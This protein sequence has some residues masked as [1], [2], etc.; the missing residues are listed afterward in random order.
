MNRYVEFDILTVG[1]TGNVQEGYES[2]LTFDAWKAQDHISTTVNRD[3]RRCELRIE[4][5]SGNAT[6]GISSLR[7][8]LA[9]MESH[10]IDTLDVMALVDR[11]EQ[12]ETVVL[13][14]DTCERVPKTDSDYL[15][16]YRM[17]VF[18]VQQRNR[19]CW[20]AYVKGCRVRDEELAKL[21]ELMVKYPEQAKSN[22]EI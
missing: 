6:V 11:D 16:E 3:V 12:V 2:V 13:Y 18:G 10:G 22:M 20:N 17:Y 14:S 1:S 19:D 9:E 21:K 15:K 4:V 7:G 8:L 5:D